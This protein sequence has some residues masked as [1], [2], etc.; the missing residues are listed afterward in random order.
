[1]GGL[2]TENSCV[3]KKTWDQGGIVPVLV[4][5]QPPTEYVSSSA[6]F[7]Q[8]YSQGSKFRIARSLDLELS[9]VTLQGGVV[10]HLTTDILDG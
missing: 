1:M 2:Q 10:K 4:F 6:I 8:L 7:N 9:T 3:Y 5:V